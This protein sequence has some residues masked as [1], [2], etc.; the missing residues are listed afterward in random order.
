MELALFATLYM[1]IF[2]LRSLEN[3]EPR[4]GLSHTWC[5]PWLSRLYR[6][7]VTIY[8]APVY[9]HFLICAKEFIVLW[10]GVQIIVLKVVIFSSTSSDISSHDICSVLENVTRTSLFL[11][12]RYFW[13]VMTSAI[14]DLIIA[15]MEYQSSSYRPMSSKQNCFYKF[16]QN[17]VNLHPHVNQS[18]FFQSKQF[19]DAAHLNTIHHVYSVWN[20]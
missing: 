14:F 12:C 19:F 3:C 7:F 11:K 8:Y 10:S 16:N 15:C 4:Y 5:N 18:F 1:C 6:Y 9:S 13:Q 17:C 2:H 20:P